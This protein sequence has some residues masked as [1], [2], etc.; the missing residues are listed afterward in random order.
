[1][2][3]EPAGLLLEAKDKQ[4]WNS[5]LNGFNQKYNH[6][7][8][9]KPLLMEEISDHLYTVSLPLS[10][11]LVPC[12]NVYKKTCMNLV[13]FQVHWLTFFYCKGLRN[14]S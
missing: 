3:W 5:I 4:T 1:M 8:P 10:T 11:V 12:Y 2:L 13:E 14:W 7:S 9:K 6:L